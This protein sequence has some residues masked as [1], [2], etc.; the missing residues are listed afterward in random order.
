M[1]KGLDIT[2][3]SVMNR[4]NY[5]E[6]FSIGQGEKDGITHRDALGMP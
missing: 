1:P 5:L 3:L 4:P 2:V 6:I